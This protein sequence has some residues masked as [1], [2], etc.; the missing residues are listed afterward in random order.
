MR[1]SQRVFKKLPI[2]RP[3][4]YH[5]L[6]KVGENKNVQKDKMVI[7]TIGFWAKLLFKSNLR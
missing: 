2:L 3:S 6:K 4:N 5:S 7:F 1:F